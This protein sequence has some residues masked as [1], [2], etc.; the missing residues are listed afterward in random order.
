MNY[1]VFNVLTWCRVTCTVSSSISNKLWQ[2]PVYDRFATV[3]HSRIRSWHIFSG[4]SCYNEAPGTYRSYMKWGGQFDATGCHVDTPVTAVILINRMA[5]DDSSASW[6]QHTGEWVCPCMKRVYSGWKRWGND[7]R[8]A[9]YYD[10]RMS[11]WSVFFFFLGKW[12]WNWKPLDDICSQF[13]RRS[14]NGSIHL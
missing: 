1:F 7:V 2:M 8:G 14:W 4:I 9:N 12:R 3:T 13:R 11:N 10:Y 6:S 5:L